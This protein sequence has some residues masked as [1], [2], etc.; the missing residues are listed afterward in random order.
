[1][2]FAHPTTLIETVWLQEKAESKRQNQ[3]SIEIV[4]TTVHCL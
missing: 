4:R 1:M 3:L 2:G